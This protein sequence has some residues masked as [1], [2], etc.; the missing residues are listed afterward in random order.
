MRHGCARSEVI[1]GVVGLGEGIPTLAE[2]GGVISRNGFG[3]AI[4]AI[5]NISAEEFEAGI[6]ARSQSDLR[7]INGQAER[8]ARQIGWARW[9]DRKEASGGAAG[10][11]RLPGVG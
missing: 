9:R 4:P 3:G 5:G 2:A 7:S 11:E 8:G 1:A 6:H 10:Q